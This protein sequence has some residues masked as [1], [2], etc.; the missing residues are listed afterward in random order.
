M[1]IRQR[2]YELLLQRRIQ[3]DLF[4]DRATIEGPMFEAL[5][6]SSDG[7]NNT[8]T[9]ENNESQNTDC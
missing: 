7:A 6:S 1:T 2:E 5:T 4:A 8:R 3:R 9:E